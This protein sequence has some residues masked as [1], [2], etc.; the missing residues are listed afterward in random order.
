MTLDERADTMKREEVAALLASHQQLTASVGEL[1]TR[2]DELSRQLEWFKRQLFG[3]KSE[4]RVVD[5]EGRQMSLG[6]IGEQDAPA[7]ESGVSVAEHQR[8]RRPKRCIHGAIISAARS[9]VQIGSR[10]CNRIILSAWQLPV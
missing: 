2:N 6:E 9:A 1:R 5:A 7:E 8:R 4:R 3:S 10:R